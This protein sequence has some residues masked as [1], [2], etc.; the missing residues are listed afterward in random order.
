MHHTTEPS[1]HNSGIH[2]GGGLGAKSP[3]N[4]ATPGTVACQ[5]P[6]S[7]EFSRQEYWSVLPCSSQGDLPD[8]GIEPVPPALQVDSLPT[9]L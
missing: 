1:H 4:L 6:L 8:V 5:A 7:M 3:V 9:E 2:G